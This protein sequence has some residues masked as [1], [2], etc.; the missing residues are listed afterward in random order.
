M[1]IQ[2]MREF[3]AI[4]D[5]GN[6]SRAARSLYMTQPALSRHLAEMESELGVK[7]V[8]R[9][10]H[11]V[12]LTEPGERAYRSFKQVIRAY[13][14]LTEDIAGYK[15]GRTG[16]L[17]IGM[18]YYTIR[19][20]FG[21]AMERF[22]EEYPNVEL[23]RFSYQP[24]EMFQAL[25][26][27]SIDIGVLPR[28]DYP[29]AGYLRFKDILR[30]GMAALMAA[31]H[32]LAERSALS[33]EDLRG[34]TTILLRDDPCSNLCYSE[35]LGRCGFVQERIVYT[36]N[37]D[38]VPMELRKGRSVYLVPRGLMPPG[39]ESELVSVPVEADGLYV[40]KSLVWRADN[41]NPLVPLFLEMVE[42]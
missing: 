23:K 36:D 30:S 28:A 25:V 32:A 16:R 5:E 35:A 10:K 9:D 19:Q 20:D 1:R 34:E 11:S 31:N 24:Q 40:A 22:A 18:L 42:H 29:N 37:V 27:E 8:E 38:T 39:F 15:L 14:R 13:D 7:L 6:I 12:H 33:L 2:H 21:D 41:D 4:K 17:R 26:D 3:V